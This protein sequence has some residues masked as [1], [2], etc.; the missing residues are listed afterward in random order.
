MVQ[1]DGETTN[2]V[3]AFWFARAI[4][5]G[6]QEALYEPYKDSPWVQRAIKKIS[7]PISAVEVEF[8]SSATSPVRRGR[9]RS[10]YTVRGL[11]A[12]AQE[13]DLPQVRAWLREPMRGM[14]WSDFVEASIGWLKLQEC[15]WIL[16]DEM[17][18]PFPEASK[19]PLPPI[20][21]ARPDRM[22]HVVEN[23]ELTGWSYTDASGKSWAL[24]PDQVIQL[25]FWNP[26][27][28][29]RGLGEYY[30]A[31][32]AAESDWLAGKFTRNLMSNNGDTGPYIV[33]KNGIPTDGQREQILTDLR[34]KRAAQLRGNFQPIFLTGDVSIEDPQIRS[35]DA[36]F[37][38][39]RLENRHEIAMAFGVP[40]SMFDVKAAYSIG[41]ASDYFQLIMDTCIPAGNKLCS[42]LE[43][44]IQRATGKMVKVALNWDEH[45]VMQEVRKERLASVDTLA[46]RGMPI[47]DIS[48]Y[49]GLGLPRFDGDDIG[50]LPMGVAPVS[51][52]TEP[53]PEPTTSLDYSE[54]V[55]DGDE[56]DPAED[57]KKA[58]QLRA[59]RSPNA[60]LWESHMRRRAP[61]VRLYERK[62]SKALMALRVEVLRKLAKLGESLGRSVQ[63]RAP[64]TDILFDKLSFGEVLQAAFKP[65]AEA[66][67][68]NGASQLLEEIGADNPWTMPQAEVLQFVKSRENRISGISDS[69]WDKLKGSLES[70]FEAG[71]NTNEIADDLRAEFNA[72][73][74]YEARRIAMTET[75]AAFNFSRDAAMRGAGVQYKKWL[76]SHGP[77]VRP[78]HEAAEA[79]YAA[80]PIPITEPFIV[81]GEELMFPGDENGS[82]GN[83]INC[84]CIS[85]AVAPPKKPK[86]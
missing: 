5:T 68:A 43:V 57:I 10:L 65:V 2:G 79:A 28:P 35:V 58:F 62:F 76:S 11:R 18:V 80:N 13:V 72:L 74:K 46:N 77:N 48:D 9:G 40:P 49:L 78:A 56:A 73:S 32:I 1:K 41:S 33:A 16:S 64:I 25:R 59:T 42:A 29:F 44:L 53:A 17:L 82:A 75:G 36:A 47:H 26:Y 63:C 3:P 45:P 83:V 34:A 38:G 15:F 12:D 20:I 22:R 19:R 14:T 31:R 23:G 54:T 27:D 52:M 30:S 4:E 51:D 85:L 55:P 24:L 37:L 67:M 70:G 50:Y 81:G 61:F 6:S 60:K 71:K 69:V 39:N 21:I 8:L 7:G 84:E 66:A 86:E